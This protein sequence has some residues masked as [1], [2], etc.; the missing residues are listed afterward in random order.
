M[1][2]TM[3]EALAEII[4]EKVASGLYASAS[5][6]IHEA[7]RKM[8]SEDELPPWMAGELRAAARSHVRRHTSK[9]IEDIRRKL[10]LDD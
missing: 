1:N 3:P 10:K 7:V 6:V 5:A 8:A 9:D 2:I 4:E